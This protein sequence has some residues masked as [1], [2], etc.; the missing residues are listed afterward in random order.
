MIRIRLLTPMLRRKL[1]S[2]LGLL[3][4]G[5]FTETMKKLKELIDEEKPSM[6]ISVGDVVSKN[7][8]KNGIQPEV[9]I[10]DNTVMRKKI[11]PIQV[12]ADQTLY[13][14][15]LPG[16]LNNEAWT[17]V[18]R[19][20]KKKGVTRVL[21][22][23]EEDLLTLVAVLCAPENSLVVYGQPQK[24]IVAVRVT[25]QKKEHVRQIVEVMEQVDESLK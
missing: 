11:K 8:M 18:R 14:K 12:E 24:G 21:V 5:A 13:L 23:G 9:L 6:L 15:N 1:K 3:I 4:Q 2:P 7:M 25:E 19:A 17:I 22:D 20:L 16:T 10:V